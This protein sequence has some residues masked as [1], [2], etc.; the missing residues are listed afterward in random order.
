M[1]VS[2]RCP[3]TRAAYLADVAY[4]LE[5]LPESVRH[6]SEV[7]TSGLA[8]DFILSSLPSTTRRTIIDIWRDFQ[9]YLDVQ[10]SSGPASSLEHEAIIQCSELI[11]QS[12]CSERLDS[13][14]RQT[15]HH[16]NGTIFTEPENP[17]NSDE[18]LRQTGSFL[19]ARLSHTPRSTQVSRQ[20]ACWIQS[21][22]FAQDKD[23]VRYSSMLK[24]SQI[25][26]S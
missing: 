12:P 11:Q 3:I 10:K 16:E 17:A 15:V 14:S 24:F 2:N 19:A 23:S 6:S 8:A 5:K 26:P 9:G 18:A 13:L 4:V 22:V 1:V 21:F 20:V 25:N 7:G